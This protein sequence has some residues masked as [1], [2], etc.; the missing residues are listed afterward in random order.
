MKM[1]HGTLSLAFGAWC[2]A[3]GAAQAQ[4]ETIALGV[5]S[6]QCLSEPT[7]L[8]QNRLV[9][10]VQAWEV[11][12]LTALPPLDP[13]EFTYAVFGDTQNYHM[14]GDIY[15]NLSFATRVDWLVEEG[16]RNA[17]RVRL[18]S[19]LGDVVD[20]DDER[21]WTL[22]SNQVSRLIDAGIPITLLPGNHDMIWGDTTS[23]VRH[24]PLAWRE[25]YL[26]ASSDLSDLGSFEGFEGL[27]YSDNPK[28]G[29]RYSDREADDA[30][31]IDNV[32]GLGAN[33]YQLFDFAAPGGKTFSFILIHLQCSTPKPVLDWVDGLLTTHSDRL[34][35]IINHEGLGLVNAKLPFEREVDRPNVGRMRCCRSTSNDSHSPQYQWE[36]CYSRHPNVMMILSGHQIE[37]LSHIRT[38]RG[39]YGNDVV[40][41]LQNYP[42]LPYSD[43]IRLYRINPVKGAIRCLTWSP[44]Q[45]K[46]CEG[47]EAEFRPENNEKHESYL[48]ATNC[49]HQFKI[50]IGRLRAGVRETPAKRAFTTVTDTAA[51]DGSLLNGRELDLNSYGW[52]G[53]A[54]YPIVSRVELSKAGDE[55]VIRYYLCNDYTMNTKSGAKI[56][57]LDVVNL[58]IL[59]EQGGECSEV[60]DLLSGDV[61]VGGGGWYEVRA[62]LDS[63]A[64]R[65]GLSAGELTNVVATVATVPEGTAET[66]WTLGEGVTGYLANGV[67]HVE[68][69]GAMDDFASAAD[70][71]WACAAAHVRRVEVEPTVTHL[72][73]HAFEGMSAGVPLSLTEEQAPRMIGAISP[74]DPNAI[75]VVDGAVHLTVSV[76]TNSELTAAT[77]GWGKAKVGHAE[78]E[79]DGTVTLTVPAPAER[80][81]FILKSKPAT[82]DVQ[83]D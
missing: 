71:P 64:T 61:K 54:S 45:G 49:P 46:L 33:C 42:E 47:N 48:Y 41:I 57:I 2:M 28:I 56:S 16:N 13:G 31:V 1:V 7:D 21:Q 34:A 32:G 20:R 4:T 62:P 74:A 80:G 75:E 35:I 9:G 67:L 83:R 3:H 12:D 18:V 73:A 19:H 76:S 58:R 52:S 23:F 50:D 43:W 39:L 44:Q 63:V 82:V 77:E 24:L 59:F 65:L 10:A 5:G 17:Q 29:S 53:I 40:E 15:T 70:A 30:P 72:A 81:F 51:T 60:T 78:T 22:A 38:S 69:A 37:G 8:V 11:E 79:D 26:Q 27:R 68:G 25:S 14:L 6:D 55:A 36:R 66:P